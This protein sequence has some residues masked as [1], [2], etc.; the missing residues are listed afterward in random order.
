MI[1]RKDSDRESWQPCNTKKERKV[2]WPNFLFRANRKC[3]ISIISTQSFNTRAPRQKKNEKEKGLWGERESSKFFENINCN[4]T[5]G[6][7]DFILFQLSNATYI[8][9]Y[10]LFMMLSIKFK[11]PYFRTSHIVL[12][13]P[14]LFNP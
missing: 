4:T 12:L 7:S 2:Q 14:K 6:K 1:G 3:N 5:Y 8:N 10:E 11:H 9:V 13:L